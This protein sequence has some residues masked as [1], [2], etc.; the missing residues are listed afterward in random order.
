MFSPWAPSVA[1]GG[2]VL[3]YLH[4]VHHPHTCAPVMTAESWDYWGGR[5]FCF[6]TAQSCFTNSKYSLGREQRKWRKWRQFVY[7]SS[8]WQCVRKTQHM[9]TLSLS[10]HGGM[11]ALCFACFF[12]LT[13]AQR[14]FSENDKTQETLTFVSASHST[15]TFILTQVNVNSTWLLKGKLGNLAICLFSHCPLNGE[16]TIS[17]GARKHK[18]VPFLKTSVCIKVVM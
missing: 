15:P 7:L 10:G 14:W 4:K 6:L 5:I 11:F 1:Q 2:R 16:K 8:T 12:C 3:F 9:D 18:D 17:Q 13:S